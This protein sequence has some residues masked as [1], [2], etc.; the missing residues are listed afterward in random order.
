MFSS[1]VIFNHAFVL[2]IVIVIGLRFASKPVTS[3]VPISYL[4]TSHVSKSTLH[5]DNKSSS[6]LTLVQFSAES[7]A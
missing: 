4:S 1:N 7:I 5:A 2:Y 3:Y 6:D